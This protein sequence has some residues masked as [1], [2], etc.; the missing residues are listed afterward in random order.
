MGQGAGALN[1]RRTGAARSRRRALLRRAATMLLAA[2][3]QGVGRAPGRISIAA[4]AAVATPD[5]SATARRADPPHPA[6]VPPG[7]FAQTDELA[8][9]R[10]RDDA[11]RVRGA[12]LAGARR[13]A[14]LVVGA[15]IAGLAAA[16]AL[17]LAGVDDVRVVELADVAGGNSR[18]ATLGGLPC[19]GGAHY[20]PLPGEQAPEIAAFLAEIGVRD[21]SGRYDERM[22]IHSPQERLFIHGVWQDGLLPTVAQDANT[23][24]QYR[25]FATEI[26]ALRATGGFAIPSSRARPLDALTPLRAVRFDRWLQGRGYTSPGLRWY[27]DYCC[28][29]EYGDGAQV[30]SAWA[31][32]HYFAS[33]HGF[34]LP[35]ALAADL[36]EPAD[37]RDTML[38]WPQG[39]GWLVD[40]LAAPIGER[41]ARGR[42]VHHLWRDPATSRWIAEVVATGDGRRERWAA[43]RV[44]WAAPLFVAARVVDDPGRR[45]PQLASATASLQHAPWLVAN[46]LVDARW[47][48]RGGELAW[49]NVFH[50]SA[51]LGYVDARHQ[52]VDR[53]GGDWLLTWYK[54]LGTGAG[55][56]AALASSRYP[57]IAREVVDDLSRAHPEIGPMV[58]RIEIHR[59]GHAMAVPTPKAMSPAALRARSALGVGCDGLWFA[60]ADLAGYSVFEE[61]F[62]SGHAAG[63]AAAA[64]D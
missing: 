3:G 15:G 28:R 42:A 47:K 63:T 37:D 52:R 62:C 9:H 39:N 29:D 35:P 50:A 20:L 53:L 10:L 26:D 58:R 23:F 21:A 16:R 60:H 32:L 2:R 14:V 4:A 24:S 25:R 41:L 1:A 61:A 40:R 45:T 46:V 33:R 27:L 17:R 19:P 12:S 48:P 34:V 30:V 31:G 64:S 44:I 49:D 51:S 36:A 59:W 7:G 38:T 56:R 5:T 13:C 6:A 57:E 55:V 43:R 54:A 18:A 22:L 8:G 11:P